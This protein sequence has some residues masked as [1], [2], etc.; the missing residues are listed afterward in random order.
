MKKYL[1]LLTFLP[2]ILFSQSD[3]KYIG[4]MW[5]GDEN[6]D[7]E[8]VYIEIENDKAY[9]ANS[10]WERQGNNTSSKFESSI[11]LKHEGKYLKGYIL[12]TGSST[13]NKI[14]VSW[15]SHTT[16]PLIKLLFSLKLG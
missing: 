7:F 13:K 3:G 9:I 14:L 15:H 2:T 6:S 8:P 16:D 12:L 11:V 4:K 5:F 1:F 10:N